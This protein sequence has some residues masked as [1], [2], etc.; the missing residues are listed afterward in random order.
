MESVL[1]DENDNSKDEK[2]ISIVS[3]NK[4]ANADAPNKHGKL[5]N[6]QLRAFS[7]SI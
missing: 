1:F 5:I 3:G 2:R 4:Y 6:K 7:I